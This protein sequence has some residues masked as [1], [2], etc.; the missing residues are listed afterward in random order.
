MTV[1]QE[2]CFSIN[3]VLFV[4]T[5][6]CHPTWP[7]V[8]D[9]L[10]AELLWPPGSVALTDVRLAVLDAPIAACMVVPTA[11]VLHPHPDEDGRH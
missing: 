5:L 4:G 8:Q 3:G 11:A 2:V 6:L 9:D 1:P 7:G 10:L